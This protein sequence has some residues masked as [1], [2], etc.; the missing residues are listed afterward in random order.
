MT[1]SQELADSPVV[2]G[3]AESSAESISDYYNDT[4]I[5]YEVWSKEGYLHFG[6]WRPWMN[7]FSRRPML[8]E[9]NKLIFQH[10]QLSR[11]ED[12]NIADLGCG[13]GAVSRHG[14]ELFPKLQF[15]AMTLS[16][17]QVEAA[18]QKHTSQH[19]TYYCG[20]YHTIPLEDESLDGI[21]YLESLCHSTRPEEALAEAA[22]VLK[23]GGRIVFTDGYITRPLEKTSALFRHVVKGVAHNWAVPMFHEIELARKW[24][25]GG[26]LTMVEE[27]ECGWRLGPSALHAAHLSLIHFF[28]LLFS[29][30]AS[31][32]QWRH[33][34]AS[35]Y[36]ILLGL[37]RRY[38]RYHLIVF[39]KR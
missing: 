12:G 28:K 11:L 22:R 10:L 4:V 38:F 9:M 24:T 23:P 25:G 3:P 39:E 7:P 36:T 33:L 32:W 19:V 29:G 2:D 20:D 13:I 6:Y 1:T 27:F 17:E 37:Y 5:D 31:K 26:Q 30:K 18:K 21:F 15:H 8:E 35:A 14:S 16:A 34:T